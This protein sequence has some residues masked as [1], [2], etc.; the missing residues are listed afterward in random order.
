[1]FRNA[2]QSSAE[3]SRIE[4]RERGPQAQDRTEV[5]TDTHADFSESQTL[6]QHGLVHREIDEKTQPSKLLYIKVIIR[7]VAMNSCYLSYGCQSSP[8]HK[9]GHF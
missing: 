4:E 1:M 5:S 7:E 6:W 9:K 8:L 2:E 3:Q